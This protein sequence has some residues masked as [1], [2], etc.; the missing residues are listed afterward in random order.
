MPV[1]QQCLAHF[2]AMKLG[3]FTSR[4]VL[5]VQERKEMYTKK[6]DAHAALLFCSLR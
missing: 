6:R 2:L 3:I 1:N 5:V 4:H